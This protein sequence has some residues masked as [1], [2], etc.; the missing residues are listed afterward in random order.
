MK[1]IKFLKILRGRITKNTQMEF[2]DVSE[3]LQYLGCV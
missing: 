3:I 2:Y 1:D